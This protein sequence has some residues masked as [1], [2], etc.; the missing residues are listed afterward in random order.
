MLARVIANLQVLVMVRQIGVLRLIL[1]SACL[2]MLLASVLD[3]TNSVYA[4][5]FRLLKQSNRLRPCTAQEVFGLSRAS[6]RRQCR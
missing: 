1:P 6:Y 2:S 3:K 4:T 5:G